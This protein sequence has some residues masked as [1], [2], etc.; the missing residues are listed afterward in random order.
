MNYPSASPLHAQLRQESKVLQNSKIYSAAAVA[1]SSL[2]WQAHVTQ[3]LEAQLPEAGFLNEVRIAWTCVYLGEGGGPRCWISR[4]QYPFYKKL[5]RREALYVNLYKEKKRKCLQKRR[6]Y[7][8]HPPNHPP[9]HAR[10]QRHTRIL[11]QESSE[12]GIKLNV[13]M[14]RVSGWAFIPSYRDPRRFPWFWPNYN[15]FTNLDFPDF[16]GNFPSKKL[17]FWG[18]KLVW[19][20]YNLTKWLLPWKL[21]WHWNIPNFNRKYIFQW[22]V[23]CWH[24]S[25]GGGI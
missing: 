8:T 7:I 22:W 15:I 25:F 2:P 19:G 21:T 16:F 14:S 5:C 6:P 12:T 18:P 10:T 17:H 20:R 3:R 1:R 11:W 13:T 4:K 23:F 24:V 9:T